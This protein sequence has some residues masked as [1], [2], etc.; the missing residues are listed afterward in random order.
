M[1]LRPTAVAVLAG[2]LLLVPLA[3]A[4]PAGAAERSAG[5]SA[6]TVAPTGTLAADGT[7]T[8]SGSYR[9]TASGTV[10][11]SSKLRAG[12]EEHGIGG[13]A[14]TCDGRE[15]SWTNQDTPRRSA[16]QTGPA[17]VEATLLKLDTSSG[18]PLPVLLAADRE[19]ISLVAAPN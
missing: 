8:L 7:V 3:T 6:V 5:G 11:V 16:L 9:C 14:A 4:A 17:E 19:P 13:T 1:A 2:T 18:L 15:H 10:L 12:S